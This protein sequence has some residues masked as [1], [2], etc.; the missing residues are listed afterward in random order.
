MGDLLKN[1][2]KAQPAREFVYQTRF[3]T[4]V[5]AAKSEEEANMK[6]DALEQ[7]LA[8]AYDMIEKAMAKAQAS[9]SRE[10]H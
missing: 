1:T 9:P 7:D 5:I 6:A 10:L 4:V 3:G 8:E 2:K